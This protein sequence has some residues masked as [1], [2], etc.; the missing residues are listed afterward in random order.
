MDNVVQELQGAP[1]MHIASPAKGGIAMTAQK[2]SLEREAGKRLLMLPR[3]L[4]SKA[5][6][7]PSGLSA[8]PFYIL[9]VLSGKF[10]R[11]APIYSL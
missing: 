10:D 6:D 5:P 7:S 3:F 1:E 9:P 2:A 11:P 4:F 8:S